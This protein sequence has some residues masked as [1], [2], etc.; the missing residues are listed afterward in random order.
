MPRKNN[1]VSFLREIFFE[2]SS[3]SRAARISDLS[4]G[5][6]YIDTIATV[7]EGELIT[8]DLH[9]DDGTTMRFTGRVAYVMPGMG[10]GVQFTEMSPGCKEFLY[11]VIPQE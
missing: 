4:A 8:F 3:G 9:A 10:F 1:R 11:R 2:W 5:G 6:C 7:S